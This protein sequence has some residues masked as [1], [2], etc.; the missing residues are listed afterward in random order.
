[1]DLQIFGTHTMQSVGSWAWVE[2]RE[3]QRQR[4]YSRWVHKDAIVFKTGQLIC[5]FRGHQQSTR[6][7][8]PHNQAWAHNGIRE[9]TPGCLYI[10]AYNNQ[11][12]PVR[13]L[14]IWQ[15][16]M[17]WRIVYQSSKEGDLEYMQWMRF[18]TDKSTSSPIVNN[19]WRGRLPLGSIYLR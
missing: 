14:R 17:T 16:M 12:S 10:N 6:P 4:G 5:P 3:T 8:Q 1:M 9:G 18:G 11:D 13:W 7:R 19:P 2:I 15:G